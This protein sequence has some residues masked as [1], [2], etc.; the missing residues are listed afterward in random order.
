MKILPSLLPLLL[1]APLSH[2][3]TAAVVSAA[4][5]LL[6]TS[7]AQTSPYSLASGYSVS[8]TYSLSNAEKW[9][10]LPGTPPSDSVR[11]GPVM[12]GG[13]TSYN[14]YELS[15]TISSGQTVSPRTAAL[16]LAAAAFSTA[17]YNMMYEIRNADDLLLSTGNSGYNYGDYRVAVLGTPSTSS[18]WMIKFAGHHLAY[19]LTYN[20]PYVSATPMFL[21]LEPPDYHSTGT[22][23]TNSSSSSAENAYVVGTNSSTA[24]DFLV[25][26]PYNSS[27]SSTTVHTGSAASTL[28]SRVNVTASAISGATSATYSIASVAD[29]DN[30]FYYCKVTNSSGSTYSNT[31]VL[32]VSLTANSNLYNS[33][34][35]TGTSPAPVIS[36]QP[37]SQTVTSGSSA[38]FTVAASSATSY[39]WYKIATTHRAAMDTQ[40]AA[41]CALATALQADSTLT[42]SAKLSG[43]YSDVVMGV[44]NSG[45]T[46]FPFVS[47]STTYPTGT[48]GRGVLFS[49]LSSSQQTTL[50]PLIKAVIEAWANIPASDVS[51]SLIADYE[52]DPALNATYV[53]YQVGSGAADTSGVT[54]CN[55]DSTINQEKTPT[56]SQHSYLRI[57]GPRCW[58]EMVVQNAVIYSSNGFIHYHSLW[59]DK[60]ADYGNEFGGYLDTSSTSTTY[61]RPS[62]STQPSS[63][64]VTAGNSL[65]LSVSAS[66]TSTLA[67]Q[68]YKDDAAISGATSSSYTISSATASSAGSYYVVVANA[69]GT[70]SSSSATVTVTGSTTTTPSTVASRLVQG[71]LTADLVL[72]MSGTPTVECRSGGSSGV[73]QLV[74]DFP[75]TVTYSSPRVTT[76]TATISSSSL[77]SSSEITINLTGVTNAQTIGVTVTVSDGSSSANIVVPMSVLIGDTNGNGVVNASDVSQVKAS[78]GVDLSAS[79]ARLDVTA[80][81]SINSSDVSLVKS[82]IGTYLP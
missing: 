27:S 13:P 72:N 68:W 14:S 51:S 4:N 65:A 43:T 37:S 74:L 34:A 82:L 55:F 31:A 48:S 39:Q 50:K 24:N 41:V 36:T 15:S 76:G 23:L 10:N 53:A 58:I 60:L 7:T 3:D 71:S 46:N 17:G 81:G 1:L 61:T 66:G 19:N 57:D 32:T 26:Y 11:V 22:D 2:A 42:T 79:N 69:Y 44:T 30:G 35:S 70:V 38:T 28:T 12:G 29:S 9:T 52:S 77:S 6:T 62:I 47:T 80:N 63:G 54:R 40:R 18:A 64:S 49:S 73:Y 33:T 5:T 67:Y 59:R 45:D 25:S 20:G 75:N 21:G 78:V 8:Q 56:N 16:N